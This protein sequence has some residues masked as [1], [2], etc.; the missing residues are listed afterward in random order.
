MDLS[1]QCISNFLFSSKTFSLNKPLLPS[2]AVTNKTVLVG[3]GQGVL[4]GRGERQVVF[5][6][7]PSHPGGIFWSQLIPK[8]GPAKSYL[9]IKRTLILAKAENWDSEEPR[10]ALNLRRPLGVDPW[11]ATP[12]CTASQ[13]KPVR[14]FRCSQTVVSRCSTLQEL[15]VKS[16]LLTF[17]ASFYLLWNLKSY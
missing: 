15:A 3:G 4:E 5:L 10:R 7:S 2:L 1:S 12:C 14:T 9:A 8:R 11:V 17:P 16:T 13:K 6:V